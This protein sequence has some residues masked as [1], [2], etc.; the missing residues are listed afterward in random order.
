MSSV[1]LNYF[2]KAYFKMCAITSIVQPFPK[3]LYLCVFDNID[4]K[5]SG[6]V[7]NLSYSN[8]VTLR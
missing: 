3:H 5:L 7:C 2:S 4:V 6:T 1:F 8:G